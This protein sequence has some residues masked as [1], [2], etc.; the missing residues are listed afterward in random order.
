MKKPKSSKPSPKAPTAPANGR[1]FHRL[2]FACT[3]WR[4][5][6]REHARS[7]LTAQHPNQIL[8]LAEAEARAES[9]LRLMIDSEPWAEIATEYMHNEQGQR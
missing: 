5:A 2:K 1:A 8:E 3:E 6:E 7:V 4:R 9:R